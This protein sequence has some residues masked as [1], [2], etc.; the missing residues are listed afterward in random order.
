MGGGASE[1]SNPSRA[2]EWE[3]GRAGTF[4]I[5]VLLALHACDTATDDALWCGVAS[6]AAVIV[7]AP[8]CHKE[9]R[10]Q[11][12][13]VAPRRAVDPLAAAL[14]H[15]IYRE[16]TA[17]MLTDSMRA[18]LLEMAGYEVSVF[19][20]VGGEHTAKNVMIPAVKLPSRRDEPEGS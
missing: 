16:R 2:D 18:L 1:P 13:R 7:V 5:D 17:E 10:R 20:F 15:G 14:R 19:E 12:E 4:G 8:C 11:I 3:G 6:G 9:V